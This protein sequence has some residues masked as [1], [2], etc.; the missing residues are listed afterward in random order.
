MM[1]RPHP[2]APLWGGD[3]EFG[4]Q[5]E[6]RR[7]GKIGERSSEIWGFSHYPVLI[8]LAINS[9]IFPQVKSVLPVV[10]IGE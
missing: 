3:R 2:S 9:N 10:V 7:K 5:V 8:R 1:N 6:P 4:S